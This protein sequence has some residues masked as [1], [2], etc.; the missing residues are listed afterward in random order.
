[1]QFTDTVQVL[2]R[3]REEAA[4]LEMRKPYSNASSAAVHV[5]EHEYI[6][7][8][9]W[10]AEKVSGST[11]VETRAML[12][13]KVLEQAIGE[14]Y[15]REHG[16]I[17]S[18]LD[19]VF[20]RGRLMATPDFDVVA[21]SRGRTI[22][23]VPVKEGLEVKGTPGRRSRRTRYWQCVGLLAASDWDAVHLVELHS[24]DYVP[25]Y[26]RRDEP[27]VAADIERL[28]A[29]IEQD[30]LYVDGG[31]APPDAVF[32]ADEVLQA[33]P[34]AGVAKV[35]LDRV[36]ADAVVAKE[37]ARQRRLAA[38][39]EEEEAKGIIA[40]AMRDAEVG[41]YA[42]EA[43]VSW[44]NNKPGSYFAEKEHQRL[45]PACHAAHSHMKPGNRVMKVLGQPRDATPEETWF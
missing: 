25:T 5:R 42:G 22:D 31:L 4:W 11:Q 19:V 21:S 13:G 34:V 29:A 8:G 39:K 37:A 33:W 17:I 32:D 20:V 9:H 10:Y 3:P 43:I 7:I 27:G 24:D 2:A 38:E 15:A 41:T 35:E 36:A 23:R 6:T 45:Q 44:K 16:L 18:P 14:W 28:M 26:L 12:R 30:W 40:N 1:M